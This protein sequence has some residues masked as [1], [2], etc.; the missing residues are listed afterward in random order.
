MYNNIYNSNRTSKVVFFFINKT[1]GTEDWL[2]LSH[3]LC[4]T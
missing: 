3:A 4:I 1:V 2:K